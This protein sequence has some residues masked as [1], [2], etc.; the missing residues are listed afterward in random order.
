MPPWPP[1]GRPDREIGYLESG[2]LGTAR[3][4]TANRGHIHPA[5]GIGGQLGTGGG[6]FPQSDPTASTT[7][8]TT[9]AGTRTPAA[10]NSLCTN[11]FRSPALV[12]LAQLWTC[13]PAFCRAGASALARPP[14][15]CST[16]RT[17][18]SG[19]SPAAAVIRATASLPASAADSS[20]IT[21]SSANNE[22]LSI[23]QLGGPSVTGA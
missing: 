12:I 21:R 9:S 11:S 8:C 5:T 6:Q 4:V 2:D 1:D 7:A 10:R 23:G 18:P 16:T 19:R 22:G 20:T 17:T 13:A 14:P 3:V 15:E